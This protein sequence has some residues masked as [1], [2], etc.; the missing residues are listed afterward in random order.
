M[1]L[2]N[3]YQQYFQIQQK[4]RIVLLCSCCKI[5]HCQFPKATNSGCNL[6]PLVGNNNQ[7]GGAINSAHDA[8]TENICDIFTC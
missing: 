1:S 6:A 4:Y 7:R 5:G 2:I 8:I 3:L